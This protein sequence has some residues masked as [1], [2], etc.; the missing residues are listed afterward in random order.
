MAKNIFSS[1]T[2]AYQGI[3]KTGQKISGEIKASHAVL[4]AVYLYQKGI[5][6]HRLI[7]ISKAPMKSNKKI[8]PSDIALFSRQLATMIKAGIPLLQSLDIVANGQNNMGLKQLI[9]TIKS[10]I[11]AGVSLKEALAQHPQYFNELVANLVGV[12]EKSGTLDIMLEQ[13]A[14]YKEK[15]ES[16]KKRIKKVLTYPLILLTITL[17]VTVG[18][19]M[20]I[21][22]QFES[23]F[24][25]FEAELPSITQAVIDISAFTH[26]YWYFILGGISMSSYAFFYLKKHSLRFDQRIDRLLLKCPALGGILKKA[27]I[28]RFSR[29]L[30]ICY[31]AGLPLVEAL[32]AVSAATGNS[33]YSKATDAIREEL[34]SGQQMNIAMKQSSLFPNLVIQMVAVGEES[35]TLEEMLRK[36][37]DIYEEEVDN[38]VETLNNLLEPVIITIL[39]VLIGGLV[40]SMYLPIFKLGSVA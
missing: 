8:K 37:A 13:I 32:I 35:G 1:A 26:S 6:S 28:T 4:A 24:T 3:N 33:V 25:G 2:F 29:T 7:K 30:A 14:R 16:L 20:F 22:P 38:A 36:I 5:I 27:A 11:E 34:A 18:L 23:L 31:A 17:L 9:E 39:G 12:G 19:L 15:M 10:D 40:I 21:V